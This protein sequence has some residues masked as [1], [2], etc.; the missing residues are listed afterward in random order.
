[1]KLRSGYIGGSPQT[2]HCSGNIQ[3]N[4]SV[5]LFKSGIFSVFTLLCNSTPELIPM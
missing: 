2:F 3:N 1:M 4:S 5:F